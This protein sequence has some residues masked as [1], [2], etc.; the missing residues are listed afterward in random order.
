MGK[1][2]RRPPESWGPHTEADQI[3]HC[4]ACGAEHEAGQ[5][6]FREGGAD[7]CPT[8]M[9]ENVTISTWGEFQHERYRTGERYA[10]GGPQRW[11]DG[12]QP[13]RPV[14]NTKRPNVQHEGRPEGVPLNAP[15]GRGEER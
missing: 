11:E 6:F 2:L 15:V 10:N 3:D 9:A 14:R 13:A 7:V 1:R 5:V 4:G 12:P 8:C